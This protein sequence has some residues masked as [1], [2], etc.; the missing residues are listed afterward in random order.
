[1]TADEVLALRLAAQD[2][3]PV[4]HALIESGFRGAS[5]RRGW[6]HEADLL[7]DT[8]TTA[9]E[10]CATIADP[11]S[12]VL[13]LHLAEDLIGTVTVTNLGDARAYMGMLCVDPER[14]SRGLGRRLIA[15]A[16]ALA[17]QEFGA[18]VIEMTVIDR[19]PEL[20]TVYEGRGYARTGEI[21]PFPV[22][23]REPLAFVV[24]D[25]AIG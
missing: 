12:R 6:S 7:D 25:K 21:R 23:S 5:A 18:R 11:Q 24:L 20:I 22:P 3:V 2:D 14:Q 9:A 8:R 4:L 16:E 13:L 1:M 17:V 10:L 15:A 19:R